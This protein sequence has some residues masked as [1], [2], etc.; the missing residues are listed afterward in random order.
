MHLGSG[1]SRK[2][3]EK[4]APGV[5]GASL[6]HLEQWNSLQ[7][8]IKGQKDSHAPKPLHSRLSR[9]QGKLRAEGSGTSLVKNAD[10]KRTKDG[11]SVVL[12]TI[13]TMSLFIAIVIALFTMS[14]TIL[15][16]RFMSNLSHQGLEA[17]GLEGT[18]EGKV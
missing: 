17:R 5:D 3:G 1:R 16:I 15:F 18:G 10:L 9:Q 2:L 14:T 4:R 12:S 13:Q 7:Q 11:E 8:K 6:E